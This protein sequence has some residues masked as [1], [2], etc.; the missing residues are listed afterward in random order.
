MKLKNELNNTI[1]E[2]KKIKH[3]IPKQIEYLK[4]EEK[5]GKC[6]DL[7]TRLAWDCLHATI[8]SSQICKWYKQYNCNDNHIA[9]LAKRAL[10][11][12]YP[13]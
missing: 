5:E 13:L 4:Q 8:P 6:K 2:F 3:L 12:V 11:E 9:T 10:K 1:K 7:E